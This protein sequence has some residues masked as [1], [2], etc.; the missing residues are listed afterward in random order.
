MKDYWSMSDE[1]L[2]SEAQKYNIP[3]AITMGGRTWIDRKAT[4]EQLIQRD[5]ALAAQERLL[6]TQQSI[7]QPRNRKIG[8]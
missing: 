1:E 5:F 7:Y 8:F 2:M 4:I 6:Q 3:H